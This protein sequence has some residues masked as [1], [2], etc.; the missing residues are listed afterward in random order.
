[1]ENSGKNKIGKTESIT[2]SGLV[3]KFETLSK[4]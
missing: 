4:H 3:C 1:M 2:G